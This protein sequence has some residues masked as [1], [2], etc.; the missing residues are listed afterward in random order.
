[1]SEPVPVLA[2]V[3][4]SVL[5]EARARGLRG[6]VEVVWSPERGWL[7]ADHT[8]QPCIHTEGLPGP[9]LPQEDS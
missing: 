5:Q 3:G 8:A 4:P 6:G 2:L 9:G 7:C 1:M